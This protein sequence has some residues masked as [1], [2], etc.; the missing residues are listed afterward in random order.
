M[1]T[2]NSINAIRELT[3]LTNKFLQNGYQ[4]LEVHSDPNNGKNQAIIMSQ[5]I[6][7][8]KGQ[9]IIVL[10]KTTASHLK[11]PYSRTVIVDNYVGTVAT[12]KICDGAWYWNEIYNPNL[13]EITLHEQLELKMK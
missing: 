12:T 6:V 4:I 2:Q 7:S 10:F 3:R 5:D 1:S 11:A 9:D 8:P 13:R